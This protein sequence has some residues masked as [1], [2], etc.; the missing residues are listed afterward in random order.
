MKTLALLMALTA[1]DCQLTMQR[2]DRG[3]Y[4]EINPI[5]RPFVTH[6]P[7]IGYGSCAADL[8][9]EILATHELNKHGHKRA[10]KI[11]KWALIGTE[12]AA[13]AYSVHE[14]R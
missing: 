6:G 14:G 11:F 2:L 9:L 1:T 5:A 10:A 7:A 3:G 4:R 8:G 13:V 12:S